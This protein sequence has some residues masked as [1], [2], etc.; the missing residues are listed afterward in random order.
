MLNILKLR[1]S[2]INLEAV[3]STDN[4]ERPVD[5]ESKINTSNHTLEI[6][7]YQNQIEQLKTLVADLSDKNEILNTELSELESAKEQYEEILKSL[8]LSD[9]EREKVFIENLQR[10]L[11]IKANI[12]SYERKIE[13]LKNE[14]DQFSKE[15]KMLK[16]DQIAILHDIKLEMSEKNKAMDELKLKSSKLLDDEIN[17]DF[18]LENFSCELQQIKVEL[19]GLCFN[20]LKNIKTIDTENLLN[21]DLNNL[22]NITLLE[23]NLST[24]LITREEYNNLKNENTKLRSELEKCKVNEKCLEELAKITQSQLLS[25]QQLIAKFSDDEISTRHL[26]VDLQAKNKDNYLLT[27]A[28]KELNLAKM[29]E[30]QLKSQLD[31]LQRDMSNMKNSLESKEKE[32]LER[33]DNLKLIEFNSTLKIRS[34]RKENI[35]EPEN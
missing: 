22:E 23:N 19:S 25:Q 33:E 4:Q 15:L 8:D 1:H 21:V 6:S 24:S 32:L 34:V 12:K 31:D 28:Q 14:N 35:Y 20:I 26:L 9:E 10:C 5:N 3:D 18:G 16:L 11:E 27:K 30:E 13:F 7:A 2:K 17:E 29:H